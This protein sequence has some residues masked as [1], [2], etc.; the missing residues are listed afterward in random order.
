MTPNSIKRQINLLI[1]L[2][3]DELDGVNIIQPCIYLLYLVTSIGKDITTNHKIQQKVDKSILC[4]FLKLK[5]A[6]YLVSV[7][8]MPVN[9]E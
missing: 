7:L 9:A 3:Q 4:D 5:T 8:C 2:M 1:I 6:L